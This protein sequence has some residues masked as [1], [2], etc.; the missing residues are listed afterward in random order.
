MVLQPPENFWERLGWQHY[1]QVDLRPTSRR[2]TAKCQFIYLMQNPNNNKWNLYVG[3]YTF[4]QKLNHSFFSSFNIWC[5]LVGSRFLKRF[6][7]KLPTNKKFLL[8]KTIFSLVN[9]RPY[10]PC[11]DFCP[12]S[13]RMSD[14]PKMS[15]FL[16]I[17]K[18]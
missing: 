8:M 13:V 4:S 9:V 7:S 17:I 1:H 16:S 2:I 3:W 18:T 15:G 10:V 5:S 6:H 12:M 11:P 14:C